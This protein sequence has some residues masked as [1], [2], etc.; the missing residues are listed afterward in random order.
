MKINDRKILSLFMFLFFS[1][2]DVYG[3]ENEVTYPDG[4]RDW[5]HIKSQIAT[6]NHPRAA[7]IGGIHHIY[8]NDQALLGYRE[9]KFPEGSR[10]VFDLLELH[11][12]EGSL[13]EGQRRW[14]GVMEKDSKKYASTGNWGYENFTGDSKSDRNVPV[15]G[16]ITNCYTCHQQKVSKD[17]V[18]SSLR[19]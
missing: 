15:N 10:I 6:A 13:I 4:Y 2:C 1:I 12:K 11:E 9:G 7:A 16:A 3:G 18:F 17:Y 14:I 8:A 19:N 5:H